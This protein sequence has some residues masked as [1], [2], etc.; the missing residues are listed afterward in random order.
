MF[1][2][3]QFRVTGLAMIAVIASLLIQTS[4]AHAQET[5]TFTA[6]GLFST[7]VDSFSFFKGPTG[8]RG[9]EMT[10]PLNATAPDFYKLATEG[11]TFDATLTD[12]GPD[13]ILAFDLTQALVSSFYP[14]PLAPKRAAAVVNFASFTETLRPRQIAAPEIDAAST[15]SSLFLL[16]GGLMVLRG[17]RA[18]MMR[19]MSR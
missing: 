14:S 6:D 4:P 16:A 8:V 5:Y 2:A 18:P 13:F 11:K 10:L 7:D 3:N 12:T 1:A 19:T 9:V 15:L 17:R